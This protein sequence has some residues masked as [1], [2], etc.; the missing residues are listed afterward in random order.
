[1]SN[2]I[3]FFFKR[4]WIFFGVLFLMVL[5][6]VFVSFGTG[7]RDSCNGAGRAVMEPWQKGLLFSE[8]SQPDRHSGLPP[9]G[10]E[11][12][13]PRAIRPA[14]AGDRPRP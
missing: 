8:R 5:G 3:H 1:M 10:A 12:I 2:P 14:F 6:S 7:P 9:V 4:G 11:L 13:N